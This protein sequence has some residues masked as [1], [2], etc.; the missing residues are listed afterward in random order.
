MP[1]TTPKHIFRFD[2]D[3]SLMEAA[4]IVYKQNS[5]IVLEKSL[6]DCEQVGNA[7]V[8]KLSQEETG[9]FLNN[10]KVSVQVHFRTKKGDALATKPRKVE[11]DEILKREV[12]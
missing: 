6:S 10:I 11:V 2:F 12:I 8:L 1:F 4:R 9:L 3:T 5:N 7:L